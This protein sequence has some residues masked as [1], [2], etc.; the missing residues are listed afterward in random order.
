LKTQAALAAVSASTGG[1]AMFLEEPS[2]ADQIYSSIFADINRRYIVGYY[3]T[4]KEHDGKRR[5]IEVTVRDHS[6]YTV[7]AAGG[8]TRRR[9]ISEL[10]LRLLVTHSFAAQNEFFYDRAPGSTLDVSR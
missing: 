3:P 4:N 8:I 1:W 7:S 6:D 2:Q 10:G 5:K 9:R